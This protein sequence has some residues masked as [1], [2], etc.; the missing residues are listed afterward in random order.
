MKRFYQRAFKDILEN[1]FLTMISIITIALSILIASSFALF[2]VNV[3]D[4]FSHWQKGIRMMIYL[5]ADTSEAVRLDT[6]LR[7]QSIAGVHDAV[8]IS[9]NDAMQRLKGQM[10]HHSA[11]LENLKENPL[12]EAF[13]LTLQPQTR[14]SEDLRFLAE[15][16]QNLPAVAEVEY[17]RQWIQRFSSV[18]DLFTL[19]GYAIGGLFFMAT[20]F[21]VANTIRLVLY[22]R[23]EEIEIMRLVGATDRFIKIPFY[24]EGMIQG[25]AG[26]LVGLGLLYLGYFFLTRNFESG[27]A[28][29]LLT[30]RFFSAGIC[31]AIIGGGAVIGWLGCWVSL[32]QFL[33]S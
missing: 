28:G 32:K 13:E 15:R 20:V 12:P 21:I 11:L 19:A 18:V 25:G 7:L 27:M 14:N 4:L 16:I 30:V 22:S 5:K 3:G 31:A 24:L 23:R 8:Y 26:T 17:G 29:G 33:K 1:Q 9:K 10:Q 6:Q 2:F